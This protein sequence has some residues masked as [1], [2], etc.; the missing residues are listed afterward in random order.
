MDRLN[1]K[2][3]FGE[4]MPFFLGG[5]DSQ[6]ILPC[7]PYNE[8]RKQVKTN[9]E[10]FMKGGGYVFYNVHNIQSGVLPENII[11]MFDA[12]YDYGF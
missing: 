1:L 5:I 7:V 8:V 12:T 2:K 9:I 11:A 3:R 6:K 10:I 4:Q